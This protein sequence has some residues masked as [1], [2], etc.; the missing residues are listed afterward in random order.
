L[1]TLKGHAEAIST[2]TVTPDNQYVLSGST[3][4]TLIL[5]RLIWVLDFP[6]EVDW[7]YRVQPFLENFLAC[8]QSEWTPDNW[9]SLITDLQR[10]GF[11]WIRSNGIK[12][13]LMKMAQKYPHDG[14][15]WLEKRYAIQSDAPQPPKAPRQQI[16]FSL[17]NILKWGIPLGL[18]IGGVILSNLDN[19]DSSMGNTFMMY[20][21][22]FLGL[23]YYYFKFK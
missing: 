4:K 5:W 18:I 19:N 15:Q 2:V 20:G 13:K 21:A 8:H 1:N 10:H 11:G 6:K 9:Q 22:F 12:N 7:D 14:R 3:D 23:I 16:D 17:I